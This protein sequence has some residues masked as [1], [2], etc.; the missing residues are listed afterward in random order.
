MVGFLAEL[1]V[2]LRDAAHGLPGSAL[3]I[4]SADHGHVTVAP[5]RMIV[6]EADDSLCAHLICRPTGEPTVPVFHPLPGR[7][8]VFAAEFRKRFEAE[9]RTINCRE[10][11]GV[12]LTKP[13]VL[14]D[15][16]SSDIPREVCFPAVAT[17]HRLVVELLR[18]NS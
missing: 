17:A 15:L 8:E 7:E 3:M 12:D 2:R 18:E 16:V 9:M 4:V 13:E 1:D 11:T 5:E 10:L 14:Q 6:L